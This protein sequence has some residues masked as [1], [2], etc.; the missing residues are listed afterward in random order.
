MYPVVM[1]CSSCCALCPCSWSIPCASVSHIDGV[2]VR[3]NAVFFPQAFHFHERQA[4]LTD[5]WFIDSFGVWTQLMCT[6]ATYPVHSVCFYPEDQIIPCSYITCRCEMQYVLLREIP[7]FAQ[8][9][10]TRFVDWF[11]A[12]RRSWREFLM[13]ERRVLLLQQCLL[14]MAAHNV[15]RLRAQSYYG[16]CLHGDMLMC[17]QLLW[18]H[19]LVWYN[20]ARWLYC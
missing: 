7:L 6:S 17:E 1:G 16:F 10:C 11:M 19:P 5:M 14:Q 12:D 9:L 18:R 8:H 2:C 20:H 3:T 4:G 13:L 15:S